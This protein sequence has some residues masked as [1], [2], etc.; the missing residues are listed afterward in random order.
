[1]KLCIFSKHLQ[2]LPIG[3]AAAIAAGIGFDGVDITVRDGGHVAPQR[4]EDELPIAVAAVRKSGLEVPMI[5]TGI[6]D[7]STP[8]AAS[9]LRVAG[10][11]GIRRY[12]WGGFKYHPDRPIPQQLADFT[13]RARELAALNK[14]YGVCAMY[15]THSGVGEVGASIWDLYM[16]LEPLDR[17]AV[18]INYDIGHATIEGGL[19][20][21]IDTTRLTL[22]MMRGIALKDFAW[23]KDADGKWQPQWRP[24]GEGMVH[25]PQFLEMVRKG[26]F[27]GP[28]QMHFEYAG[29]GGAEHGHPKITITR[30]E[31][32]EKTQR[33][34]RRARALLREARLS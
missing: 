26:G 22:P 14:E 7:A 10:A 8:H 2:W 23:V 9:V 5:T 17:N 15:H 25:F 12:R 20:G 30:Q 13:N 6:V 3:D 1:L 4:V 21:W 33:D 28:V 32:I 16:I 34:V 24:L 31:F 19:G 18:A 29:L 27:N 11:L